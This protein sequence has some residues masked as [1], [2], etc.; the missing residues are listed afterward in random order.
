MIYKRN[1]QEREIVSEF[2]DS[3]NLTNEEKNYPITQASCICYD[4]F[5][6][7]FIVSD[8]PGKW[9]LPGGKP[10][11][12]ESL[13]ES[14]KREVFE[15]ACIEIDNLKLIGF[16]KI[17]IKNNP[18]KIEGENFLQARFIGKISKILDSREDPATGNIFKRKFIKPSEFTSFINWPEAK[19]LINKALE[20]I[21]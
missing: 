2:V 1:S 4:D 14:A 16:M 20:Y 7:I 3:E 10:E 21:N 19:E 11:R 15:E 8:K 9:E 18:N 5:G 17:H 6:K 12:G 13:K